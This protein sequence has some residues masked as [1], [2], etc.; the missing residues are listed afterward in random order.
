MICLYPLSRSVPSNPGMDSRLK[1]K[2]VQSYSNKHILISEVFE[3]Q[4]P[5]NAD[6]LLVSI[7]GMMLSRPLKP[8]WLN[9][10][11]PDQSLPSVMNEESEDGTHIPATPLLASWS[12]LC[13]VFLMVPRE[14]CFMYKMSVI[15]GKKRTAVDSENRVTDFLEACQV[16]LTLASS[17]TVL[18]Q[19]PRLTNSEIRSAH[20]EQ[21]FP[22]GAD[23]Q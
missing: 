5:L 8:Y 23:S 3:P 12:C 6:Q 16:V 19:A 17:L 18:K 7:C 9:M 22:T 14:V 2:K 21:V 10:D 15:L 11:F 4:L 20:Q 1:L 13:N